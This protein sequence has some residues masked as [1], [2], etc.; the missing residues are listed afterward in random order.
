MLFGKLRFCH[1]DVDFRVNLA[2]NA[3]FFSKIGISSEL[4]PIDTHIKTPFKTTVFWKKGQKWVK[5]SQKYPQI[6]IEIAL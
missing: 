4:K 2:R 1:R 3:R 6:V 5:N